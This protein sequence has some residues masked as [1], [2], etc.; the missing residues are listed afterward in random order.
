MSKAN[1]RA[2]ALLTSVGMVE[3]SEQ[4]LSSATQNSQI[5]QLQ[6][7]SY[8]HFNMSAIHSAHY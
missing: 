3:W 5:K 8:K 7:T 2:F 6:S 4:D 1:I